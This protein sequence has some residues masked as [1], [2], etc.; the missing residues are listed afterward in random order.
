[1]V[2]GTGR[3]PDSYPP[4]EKEAGWRDVES[5]AE[6]VREAGRRAL[7]VTGDIRR[8]DDVQRMVEATMNEFAGWTFSSTT[9]PMLGS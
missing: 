4:D 8:A 3:S 9:P 2:T 7:P 5:T 1:M 6:Q